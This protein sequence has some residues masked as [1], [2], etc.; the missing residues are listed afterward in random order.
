MSIV[1]PNADDA[2]DDD[3]GDEDVEVGDGTG[4]CAYISHHCVCAT[5]APLC[6]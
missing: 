5:L 4:C 2:D 1:C 6:A 3:H